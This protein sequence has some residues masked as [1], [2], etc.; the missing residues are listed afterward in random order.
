[1]PT[2]PIDLSE[3]PALSRKRLGDRIADVLRKQIVLGDLAPG[4]RIPERETAIALGVSR[5]PLREALVILESEGLLNMAPAR[6]PVVANP[7]PDD[8]I[9]LLLVQNARKKLFCA[10]FSRHEP[11][12][13]QQ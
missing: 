8:L 7:T 9:Q 12:D 1:M 5:T 10:A 4:S 11:S 6:S 13:L 3:I 2:T